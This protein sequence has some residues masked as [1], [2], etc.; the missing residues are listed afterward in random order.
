M[1]LGIIILGKSYS[2]REYVSIVMIS[3]GICICTLASGNQ[4]KTTNQIVL[5]EEGFSEFFWW[6]VGIYINLGSIHL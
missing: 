3:V 4:K 2:I 6:T 5:K 1:I